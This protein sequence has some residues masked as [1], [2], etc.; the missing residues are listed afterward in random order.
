MDRKKTAK[1]VIMKHRTSQNRKTKRKRTEVNT[2]QLNYRGKVKPELQMEEELKN[3][4]TDRQLNWWEG[5]GST[6]ENVRTGK[7]ETQRND[8]H[9]E[10]IY[11]DNNNEVQ[12]ELEKS[13]NRVNK[14]S[15]I[16]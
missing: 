16:P 13:K 4:E 1:R 3:E 8:M 6:G 15:D 9:W 10:E 14:K 12:E 11:S 2:I 5:N 7:E